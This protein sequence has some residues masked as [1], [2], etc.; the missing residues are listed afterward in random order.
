[1]MTKEAIEETTWIPARMSQDPHL[2]GFISCEHC[3]KIIYS[4]DWGFRT[5]TFYRPIWFHTACLR[6]AK[7]SNNANGN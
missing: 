1:M 6:A 4:G 5:I 3:D 7:E 2:F